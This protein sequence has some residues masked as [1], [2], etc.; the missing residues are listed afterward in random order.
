MPVNRDLL[1]RKLEF[2]DRQLTAIERLKFNEQTFAAE[3]DV[4]DLVTFRL[5][6]AVETCIDMANHIINCRNLPRQETA[7]D[8]FI[9]L[10]EKKIINKNLSLAMSQAADFRNRV[11]HGY[12]NFDYHLLFRDYKD[13][14][15]DLR[16]FG[17]EILAFLNKV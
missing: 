17:K 2:L 13:D 6:Q 7:K 8:A 3:E 9:L 11:V 16:L 12:N 1:A 14:V 4:H 15:A 10:G 5:Q